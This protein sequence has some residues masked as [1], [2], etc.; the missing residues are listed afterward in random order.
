M[1]NIRQLELHNVGGGFLPSHACQRALQEAFSCLHWKHEHR[2]YALL[3]I[4]CQILNIITKIIL[5]F[6]ADHQQKLIIIIILYFNVYW[7]GALVWV[8]LP[9]EREG[10]EGERERR[11][12]REGGG[13]EGGG[14]REQGSNPGIHILYLW[15]SMEHL[16]MRCWTVIGERLSI[17]RSLILIVA[18]IQLR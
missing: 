18:I 13:V 5:M 6:Q 4:S 12:Q 1:Q 16:W 17:I 9:G 14:G 2:W 11:E 8:T 7:D 10:K 15:L 3:F